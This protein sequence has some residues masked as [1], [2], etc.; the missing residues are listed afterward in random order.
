M[1]DTEFQRIAAVLRRHLSEDD[2]RDDGHRRAVVADALVFN[3]IDVDA[4]PDAVSVMDDIV[5]PDC[6]D[7]CDTGIAVEQYGPDE[8]PIVC[9]CGAAGSLRDEEIVFI[10]RRAA[11][12]RR[13]ALT[14]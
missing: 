1:D 7:C 11:R 3:G 9:S 13:M 6:M 12:A 10:S 8:W 4:E 14:D 5:R 2:M